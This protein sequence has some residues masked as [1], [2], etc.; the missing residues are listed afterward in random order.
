MKKI[1]LLKICFIFIFLLFN[2]CKQKKIIKNQSQISYF[3]KNTIYQAKLRSINPM[4]TKFLNGSL[5]LLK[6]EEVLNADIRFSQGPVNTI[7]K[8]A[9]FLSTRCPS[10]IDDTNHDG[11]LD[12]FEIEHILRREII[13]LDDDLSSQRMGSGIYPKSDNFGSYQWSRQ[14]H[15]EDLLNDLLESDLNPKDHLIKIA[16][17]SQLNLTKMTVIIFGIAEDTQL[18]ETV[19][20]KSISRLF[21]LFPVACGEI[22]KIFEKPGTIDYDVGSTISDEIN[23]PPPDNFEFPKNENGNNYGDSS[24]FKNEFLLDQ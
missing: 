10:S 2:G 13:P 18:P 7:A 12:Q 9:L 19:Q 22:K 8:Q 20:S 3:N 21:E 23:S 1:S 17:A 16:N 4:I 11:Y 5:T 14:V 15:F 6:E 24:N